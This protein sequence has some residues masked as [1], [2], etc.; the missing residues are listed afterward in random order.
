MYRKSLSRENFL[1]SA[2][3]R[4]CTATNQTQYPPPF[5]DLLLI[6]V[7]SGINL[8]HDNRTLEKSLLNSLPGTHHNITTRIMYVSINLGEL[9]SW[10]TMIVSILLLVVAYKGLSTWK[11]QHQFELDAKLAEDLY[12]CSYQW[13]SKFMQLTSM[14]S[15]F[16]K[17]DKTDYPGYNDSALL[18]QSLISH[19]ALLEEEQGQLYV[20]QKKYELRFDE[21]VRKARVEL[22]NCLTELVI[23]AHQLR[24]HYLG[25]APLTH[26]KFIKVKSNIFRTG[27]VNER[28][29]LVLRVKAVEENLNQICK[30][31]SQGKLRK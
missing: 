12:I 25:I 3:P 10:I 26:D 4:D 15:E 30:D 17:V 2:V 22:E 29:P 9:T 21:G 11:K 28:N 20:L 16:P 7:V 14:F 5:V 31:L 23:S 1:D 24:D 13:I 19:S 8:Y 18:Y 27:G 6:S